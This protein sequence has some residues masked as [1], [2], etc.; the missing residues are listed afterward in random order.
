MDRHFL[1]R[2]YVLLVAGTACLGEVVPFSTYFLEPCRRGHL[3]LG[4]AILGG[5]VGALQYFPYF[6]HEGWLVT[7][8]LPRA[9]VYEALCCSTLS[10]VES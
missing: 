2:L 9:I 6:A 4:F 7:R 3:Y 10:C 8:F 1:A 5:M